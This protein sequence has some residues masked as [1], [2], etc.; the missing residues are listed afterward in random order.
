MKKELLVGKTLLKMI[1]RDKTYLYQN[2]SEISTLQKDTSDHE[3][4]GC[5]IKNVGFK[6][7]LTLLKKNC[8]K[9]N[10]HTPPPRHLCMEYDIGHMPYANC[11]KR[12]R[13]DVIRLVRTMLSTT[14]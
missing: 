6:Y 4:L 2:C 8:M 3:H 5:F 10:V 13:R 14:S 11:Y 9:H 12:R 1:T 7:A